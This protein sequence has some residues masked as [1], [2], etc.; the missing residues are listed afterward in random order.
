M[1][2]FKIESFKGQISNPQNLGEDSSVLFAKAELDETILTSLSTPGVEAYIERAIGGLRANPENLL[3]DPTGLC[4]LAT[5]ISLA[6]GTLTGVIPADPSGQAFKDVLYG[7]CA[8]R[9]SS[10]NSPSGIAD[11]AYRYAIQY[12]SS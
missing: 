10:A 5:S 12:L 2:N 3:A 4:T 1:A 9:G 6:Y 7:V 11:I 8:N